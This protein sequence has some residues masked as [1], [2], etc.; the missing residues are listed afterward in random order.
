MLKT[1][2]KFFL[3]EEEGLILNLEDI[4]F[5]K[6]VFSDSKYKLQIG[7]TKLGN[8]IDVKYN[9]LKE[10]EARLNDIFKAM[11]MIK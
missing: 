7:F 11:G 6:V 1:N 3:L 10:A 8:V 9:T 4:A 2:N 5:V